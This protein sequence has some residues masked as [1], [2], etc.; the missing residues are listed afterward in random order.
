MLRKVALYDFD[1]TIASGDTI[2]RLL[3]Y[4]L[5]KHPVHFFY[6]FKVA[7]YYFLY[8][9]HISSFEKAKSA[10]LFPLDHM[11]NSQLK[12]F[13]ENEVVPSY[14]PHMIKQMEKEHQQGYIVIV[15][16]ASC[17]VYM[18]YHQL[19]ADYLIGTR[20]LTKNG[21]PTSTVIGK[22]CKGEGKVPRIL[23]CL[24]S[25]NIEIDFENSIGYSDS[26]SDLPMLALVKNRK[27]IALKTGKISDF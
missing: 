22:N 11:D 27:R 10:L 19:P 1:N 2:V 7:F 16:T 6:F 17:E 8:L 26:T 20:T 23:E 4:D 21:Q 18:K 12:T 13:Y 24:K 25:Q 3:K 5:K 15:C 9:L 14:Y